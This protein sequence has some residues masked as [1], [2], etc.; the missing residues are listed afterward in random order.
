MDYLGIIVATIS[1]LTAV[2]FFLYLIA[3]CAMKK[4]KCLKK[5]QTVDEPLI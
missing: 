4:C 5:N 2:M 3:V 1:S